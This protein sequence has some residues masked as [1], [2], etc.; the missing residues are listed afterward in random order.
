MGDILPDL[1]FRSAQARPD[2]PALVLKGVEKTYSA[3]A[4]EVRVFANGLTDMGLEAGERVGIFLEKQFEAVTALLGVSAAGGVFVPINPA[5]RPAQVG[6][7]LRDCNVRMLVTSRR[8]AA[9]LADTLGA[10]PDLS[11]LILLEDDPDSERAAFAD[12]VTESW[13]GLLARGAATPRRPPAITDENIAGLLYTSGSTGNPK[14]VV[15]THRNFVVA[16]KTI[17]AYL[18]YRETDRILN[19]PPY[20]FGFGLSQLFTS[21]HIGAT[22]ILH[23]YLSAQDMMRTIVAERVTGVSGVP[24][25]MAQLAAMP[26][27]REAQE[28][29]RYI[30]VA[31]GRMPENAT[32]RLRQDHPRTDIYLMYGMTETLRSTYLAP[33]EADARPTSIG[34]PIPT[35]DISVLRADGT[36]CDP[37]E[38]G[39]LV[40]K[41]PLIARGYWND[42]ARTANVFRPIPGAGP[43]PAVWSGDMVKRDADGFI[44]FLGRRDEIMKIRGYRVSPVEIEDVVQASGQCGLAAALCVPTGETDQ[45]LVVYV[46]P[47]GDAAPDTGAI[48][49]YCRAQLPPYLV[50]QKI[51]VRAALPLTANG[52]LERKKLLA[53]HLAAQADAPPSLPQSKPSKAGFLKRWADE[54]LHLMGFQERRFDCAADIF[55]WNFPGRRIG[56]NDSFLTLEGDSLS[57]VS[58]STG[59]EKFLGH[60]P[61][62]WE[63]IPVNRLE[64]MR[65]TAPATSLLRPDIAVRAIALLCIVAVHAG[66]STITGSSMLLLVLSGVSFA[67]FNWSS[68]ARRT[69]VT[70]AKL[71][72][73]I[74]IPTWVMLAVVFTYRHEISWSVLFF[75]DNLVHPIRV[76]WWLPEWFVQVLLQIFVLMGLL[77]LV[78]GIARFGHTRRFA[79]GTILF[80]ASVALYVGFAWFA[81]PRLL[82]FDSLPLYFLWLFALGWLIAA[83]DSPRRKLGTYVMMLAALAAL[84]AVGRTGDFAMREHGRYWLILGAPVLLWA[85]SIAV[86]ELIGSFAGLLARATLFIYLFN[87]PL[88]EFYKIAFRMD[89]AFGSH[90]SPLRFVAGFLTSILL[91][92]AWEATWRAF[93]PLFGEAE[94][95]EDAALVLDSQ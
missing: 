74:I 38:P 19:L 33:E 20:S 4:D 24:T 34:K 92:V 5:L 18:K 22:A 42:A 80:A 41:G 86:P 55:A 8:R 17:A 89:L 76:Y 25:A 85:P 21:L 95:P 59:L 51:L 15:L 81:S 50:P 2:H 6:H 35:A 61:E 64:K 37:G 7:I 84:I 12:L 67:R 47:K 78:P 58:V 68:D 30:S 1:L 70:M 23:T 13:E 75:C 72:V 29:I 65:A 90:N 39:E 62:E 91:W 52:K 73:K 45:S 28:S 40:Q 87:W 63:A 32:R 14:G 94:A 27:P 49:D 82:D 66:Y 43:E 56:P 53:E 3:L 36:P 31:G 16:N 48:V 60:L 9:T 83:A 69:I 54:A 46:T 79:F 93:R 88:A 71:A 11:A 44:Y 77:S 57:Y 26:W 10:C